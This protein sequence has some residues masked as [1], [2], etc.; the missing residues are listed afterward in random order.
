MTNAQRIDKYIEIIDDI[1]KQ[2]NWDSEDE[3]WKD[4]KVIDELIN[5]QTETKTVGFN[6]S[7]NDDSKLLVVVHVK[8][9]DESGE[10]CA[11][12][13]AEGVNKAYV[14]KLLTQNTINIIVL[15][16]TDDIESRIKINNNKISM[17]SKEVKNKNKDIL[18]NYKIKIDQIF[19][20]YKENGKKEIKITE[21]NRYE[22][23]SVPALGDMNIQETEKEKMMSKTYNDL[24][25]YIFTA[26]LYNF[27]EIYNEIGDDLFRRNVR[28]GIK[29]NL[30]VDEEIKNTL[31]NEPETF[32]YKNNGITVLVENPLF[33]FDRA[34]EIILNNPQSNELGFSV[35][36]GAQ[37]ITAATEFFFKENKDKE[38]KEKAKRAKVLFR[39]ICAPAKVA[40]EISV[41]LNRQKPIKIEDIAYTNDFV[42][43]LNNYL[44][45][46]IKEYRISR[47]Q[48]S[49]G[50]DYNIID[51]ARARKAIAGEPGKARSSGS[52]TLLK[53]KNGIFTDTQIFVKEFGNIY[54]DADAY[55]DKNNAVQLD[56]IYNKYYSPIYFALRIAQRYE[57]LKKKEFKDAKGTIKIII[58]N[59]KW[60]FVAF[61]VCV[62]NGGDESD[63]TH[64]VDRKKQFN[65]D[66]LKK[67]ILRFAVLLNQTIND[68]GI[69]SNDFKKSD[70]YNILKTSN[71]KNSI[72]Y[73]IVKNIN[74]ANIGTLI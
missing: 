62:L 46:N 31:K 65:D 51:F 68:Q 43:K 60:Y 39:I 28:L 69:N 49:N 15:W 8:K 63:Y 56:E 34:N 44:S 12:H 20:C 19:Y 26:N 16:I 70:N 21:I 48:I 50:N 11:T 30:G 66:T 57:I 29:D 1:I 18:K 45:F 74:E 5:N 2:V 24:K 27:V 23:T 55:A 71:Y 25:G 72:F 73:H 64:F 9:G 38:D 33:K 13:V 58:D 37:T 3:T 59:G 54:E 36:N 53:V 22:S 17:Y 41:A 42:I 67:L 35:I 6:F 40:S 47:R 32:W 14:G 4:I 10:R 61:L 7:D 52:A